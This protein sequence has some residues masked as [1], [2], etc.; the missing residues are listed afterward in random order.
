MDKTMI[1]W[2]PDEES[3]V[4][5]EQVRYLRNTKWSFLEYF[6]RVNFQR[7]NFYSLYTLHIKRTVTYP[8]DSFSSVRNGTID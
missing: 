2:A 4:W 1:L 7:I 3:G 8:L 6:P 5:L